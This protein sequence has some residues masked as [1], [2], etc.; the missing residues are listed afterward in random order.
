MNVLLAIPC[1]M[2]GGTEMQTL[3]LAKALLAGGYEVHTVCYFEFDPLVVDDFILAGSNVSLLKLK[4]SV[5]SREFIRIMR[6]FY[7]A[8]KPDVLHVQYMTPGALSIVAAKLAGLS[9]IFA[10]VHQPYTKNHGLKSLLFLRTSALLCDRFIAVSMIA[11]FSWFGS[12]NNF[13][14]ETCGTFPRH[15]TLYNAVDTSRVIALSGLE[16]AEELKNRYLLSG[17]FV[18]GYIGRLSHEKGVDILLD[19][20]AQVAPGRDDVRL[21]IVGAGPEMA[22]LEVRYGQE[23]W[24][25]KIVFTGGQT[26]ENAM[27]HLSAID[28]VVVPSRFEGFGLSAVEAMAASKPVI[29]AKTGG[30]MEIVEHNR[31]GLLFDRGNCNELASL[32]VTLLNDGNKCKELSLNARLRADDFDMSHFVRKIHNLYMMEMQ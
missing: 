7:R 4:R 24:W 6:D 30:L 21:L 19:A 23:C 1:L 20:F 15:L 27:S 3:Y 26:W 31:S 12:S 14:D 28:V 17:S 13:T 25:N 22:N 16:R 5:T 32:M 10:T 29:A 18:F 2:R 11:E 9:K 8:S